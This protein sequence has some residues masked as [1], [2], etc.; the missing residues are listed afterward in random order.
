VAQVQWHQWAR[1]RRH[2]SNPLDDPPPTRRKARPAGFF[3]GCRKARP[4]NS[5]F[6]VRPSRACAPLQAAHRCRQYLSGGSVVIV[7]PAARYARVLTTTGTMRHP[8]KAA[9]DRQELSCPAA[10]EVGLTRDS[11][12]CLGSR[13]TRW[14]RHKILAHRAIHRIC[15]AATKEATFLA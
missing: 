1:K 14:C 11:P 6:V 12:L 7:A 5:V 2:A 15:T 3:V 9:S 8:L 13:G 4:P 10:A